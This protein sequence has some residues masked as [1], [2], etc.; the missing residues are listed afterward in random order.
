MARAK[1][2][3]AY[4]R[5]EGSRKTSYKKRK[6]GLLKKVQELSILCG[7][8]ACAI[9]RS[10]FDSEPGV[11]PSA[12]GVHRV[13]ER[14]RNVSEMDKAKRTVDQQGFLRH[15][16]TK[17]KVQLKK[18]RRDN[19]E[20]KV[21]TMMY[22]VIH[23]SGPVMPSLFKGMDLDGFRGLVWKVNKTLK[24]L[25]TAMRP[26]QQPAAPLS[27]PT[28]TGDDVIHLA[29]PPQ[30][31]IQMGLGPAIWNNPGSSYSQVPYS[32]EAMR[33]VVNDAP[34][35]TAAMNDMLNLPLYNDNIGMM[36]LSTSAGPLPTQADWINLGPWQNHSFPWN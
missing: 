19:W 31:T 1:V 35:L 32:E 26:S 28:P 8:D 33:G 3:L 22:R 21:A 29:A 15:R 2:K 16:I 27:G 23:E 17:L 4:I 14:F 5:H 12:D 30:Q 24:E 9:V 25:E 20:K 11:W 36:T 34:Q 6:K 18:L 10:S 13:N 7:V